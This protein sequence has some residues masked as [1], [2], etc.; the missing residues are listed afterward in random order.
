MP[1]SFTTF[2][3]FLRP[4]LS[5]DARTRLF[6][7][8]ILDIFTISFFSL[9]FLI[10]FGKLM[11][12]NSRPLSGIDSL[13]LLFCAWCISISLIYYDK[14]QISE[15]AKFILP[16]LTYVVIKSF[17]KDRAHFIQCMK[18]ML[19]AFLVPTILS[20]ILIV[21]GKGLDK[22]NYWTGLERY[23]GIF[24]N[25]HNFGHSMTLM[26]ML[27]GIY[28]WFKFSDPEHP[29][30]WL[31]KT[32]K[33]LLAL[34]LGFGLPAL[35][36]SYVRTA[37]VGLLI[38]TLVIVYKYSKKMVITLMIAGGLIAFVAAPVLKLIFL[39]V[40]E[41]SEGKRDA[42]RIGSGRPYI[43]THNLTIFSNLPFERQ[44]AGVGIG[45][46]D[47]I[48]SERSG[49]ENIWNSHNDFLEVMMQTGIVGFL[50]FVWLNLLIYFRIRRLPIIDKLPFLAL[51]FSVLF[52]N[53]ISNSYVVRFSV[54]QMFYMLLAYIESRPA[55]LT[56]LHSR[57]GK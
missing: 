16:P 44:L 17:I 24:V 38:F 56:K 7:V 19:I 34:I 31:S 21:Q 29:V 14:S 32:D 52:M 22:V 55:M 41:V 35:Y 5:I 28:I 23:Q 36:Q 37:W 39:D 33:L 40:V 1:E 6:G 27:A 8:D 47:K 53:F 3:Y 9:F 13:I 26:L 57:P 2:F 18:W 50:L 54:G 30:N 25:P 51:F 42:E 11:R 49:Q 45:N 10:W 12:G 43:W 20:V 48:F 4:M 15:V 46:R